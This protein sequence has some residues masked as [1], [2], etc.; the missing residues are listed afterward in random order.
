MKLSKEDVLYTAKLAHLKLDE[1]KIEPLKEKLTRILEYGDKLSEINTDDIAPL[2]Q[3]SESK[4][5][6]R[7]DE[8]AQGLQIDEVVCGS[9]Q[10][11]ERTVIVPKMIG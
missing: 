4:N 3:I 5:V 6:L 8:T 2:Y 7:E 9:A 11:D 1:D 10:H